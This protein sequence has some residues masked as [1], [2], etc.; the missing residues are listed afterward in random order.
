MF[1]PVHYLVKQQRNIAR[2]LLQSTDL[3]VQQISEQSGF[4]SDT[5]FCRNFKVEFGQSP[6]EYRIT[7]PSTQ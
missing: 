6:R 5:V 4:G 2:N 3:Q 1:G 7:L